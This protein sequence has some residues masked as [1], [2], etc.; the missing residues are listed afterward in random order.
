MSCVIYVAVA[1]CT[2]LSCVY[3][4][5]R[6]PKL[7]RLQLRTTRQ[8]RARSAR[9]WMAGCDG[10]LASMAGTSAARVDAPSLLTGRAA[11]ALA[12]AGYFTVLKNCKMKIKW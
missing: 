2:E 7:Q 6:I 1:N 5:P 10:T 9:W 4:Q 8:Q 3:T 11:A 12:D